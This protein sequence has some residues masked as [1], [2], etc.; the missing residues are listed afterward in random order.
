V[1]ETEKSRERRKGDVEKGEEKIQQEVRK[2]EMI[3]TCIIIFLVF[4]FPKVVTTF[5]AFHGM[6]QY[7]YCV[8]KGPPMNSVR[9]N[10]HAMS[11]RLIIVFF[12]QLRLNLP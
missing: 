6:P 10:Q 3:L 12:L 8:Y 5:F 1:E 11:L 4:L 9:F 7:Y 2:N